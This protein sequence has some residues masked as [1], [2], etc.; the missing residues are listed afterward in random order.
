MKIKNLVCADCGS[1]DCELM[2]HGQN[3][4]CI[5]FNKDRIIT[6]VDTKHVK[7][8]DSIHLY[9]NYIVEMERFIGACKVCEDEVCMDIEFEDGTITY[10]GYGSEA[11]KKL[12]EE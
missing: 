3:D 8:G 4:D 6:Y 11:I 7:I 1:N 2:V 10:A 9:K 5:W 12:L